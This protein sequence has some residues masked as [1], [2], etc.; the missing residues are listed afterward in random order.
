MGELG[1]QLLLDRLAGRPGPARR[2]LMPTRLLARGSGERELA[3][4]E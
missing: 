1:A 3:A 4:T 2:V